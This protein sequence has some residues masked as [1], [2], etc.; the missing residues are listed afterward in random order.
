MKEWVERVKEQPLIAHWI[1]AI[2]RYLTRLGI[3]S[4]AAITYFS[5][6]AMVPTLMVGF[7]GVGMT[8]TVLR[9]ELLET[10]KAELVLM[11]ENAPAVSDAL[12]VAVEQATNSWRALGLIGLATA[13][14]MGIK[15][16]NNLK[17]AVRMQL[18]ETA[19]E[20]ES[21]AKPWIDMP[22]NLAIL[23]GLLVFVVITF[24]LWIGTSALASGLLDTLGLEGHVAAAFWQLLAL[25]ATLVVT[26]GLFVFFFRV[27]PNRRP[28]WP[29]LLQGALLGAIGTTGLQGL[30]SVMFGSFS[31]NVAAAVFGPVIVLMLFFNMFAQIIIVTAAWIGTFEAPDAGE[32]ESSTVPQDEPQV[33]PGS[34]AVQAPTPASP[35]AAGYLT[36]AATGLGVGVLAS[37]LFSRRLRRE[38]ASQEADQ[39]RR[40]SRRTK[41][42]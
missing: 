32:A 14:W 11:L 21:K 5:V 30:A 33:A 20:P 25:A 3:Q 10:A 4:A 29:H 34:A 40:A 28:P 39:S 37:V 13:L 8:L 12:I 36:G 17:N 16:V 22:L 9:P 18:R 7:A 23:L 26:F 19:D 2:N 1:R 31:R 24:G 6:L 42:G 27:L 35:I 15:W 38:P 41:A